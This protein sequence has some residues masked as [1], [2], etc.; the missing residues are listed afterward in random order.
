MYFVCELQIN[1]E[2]GCGA[3][4]D[5]VEFVEFVVGAVVVEA[6]VG[7]AV[8]GAAVVAPVVV[9]GA[10][11]ALA[12][13]GDAVVAV[14]VVDPEP[15]FSLTTIDTTGSSAV[16]ESAFKATPMSAASVCFNVVVKSVDFILNTIFVA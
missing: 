8:V 13:V 15:G 4:V 14:A 16:N 5:I 10:V 6:I 9:G 2:L 1:H 3:D 11:V 12:V 7:A